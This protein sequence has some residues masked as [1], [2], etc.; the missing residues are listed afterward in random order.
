MHAAITYCLLDES[1]L[2]E[3]VARCETSDER[4]L[5]I[6]AEPGSTRLDRC[7]GIVAWTARA[8]YRITFLFRW[9]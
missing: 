6:P 8:L 2:L 9:C 1:I 5:E 4:T 7:S 3:L